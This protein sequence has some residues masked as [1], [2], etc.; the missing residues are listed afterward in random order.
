MLLD[1]LLF[2][3]I[4]DTILYTIDFFPTL[5]SPYL[6]FLSKIGNCDIDFLNVHHLQVQNFEI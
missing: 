2:L 6:F 1:N 5:P 4:Y 3:D